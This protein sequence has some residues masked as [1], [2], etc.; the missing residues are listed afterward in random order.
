[1]EMKA[2]SLGLNLVLST[3]HDL[4]WRGDGGETSSALGFR[5]GRPKIAD[6][7]HSGIPVSAVHGTCSTERYIPVR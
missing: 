7:R 1:M 2:I 4:R 3:I 6:V 5:A